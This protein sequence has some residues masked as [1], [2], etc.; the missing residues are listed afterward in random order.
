[1]ANAQNIIGPQECHRLCGSA[2]KE[3]V[4]VIRVCPEA[5]A[6]KRQMGHPYRQIT[7]VDCETVPNRSKPFTENAPKLRSRLQDRIDGLVDELEPAPV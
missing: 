2:A 4:A 5:G 6:V 7:A 3:R 1:M